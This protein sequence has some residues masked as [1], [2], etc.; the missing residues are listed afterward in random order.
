MSETQTKLWQ[1]R[2]DGPRDPVDERMCLMCAAVATGKNHKTPAQLGSDPSSC[3]VQHIVDRKAAGKPAHC[4]NHSGLNTALELHMGE[5][6][7]HHAPLFEAFAKDLLGQ[8]AQVPAEHGRVVVE[9][10]G[11][12]DPRLPDG[13]PDTAL[14]YFSYS[15]RLQVPRD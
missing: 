7:E 12:L 13:K 4:P 15:V 11:H 3:P 9:A 10:S 5:H 8:V 2:Y 1:F 14:P 6:E